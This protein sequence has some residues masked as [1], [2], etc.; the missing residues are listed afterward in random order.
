MNL[1]VGSELLVEDKGTVAYVNLKDKVGNHTVS[2]TERCLFRI[3]TEA[4]FDAYS[5]SHHSLRAFDD[6][7]IPWD[8]NKT[9]NSKGNMLLSQQYKAKNASKD[10]NRTR[11]RV[12]T[13]VLDKLRY[14]CDKNTVLPTMT[15]YKKW[16]EETIKNS[17][18]ANHYRFSEYNTWISD[19]DL[20][21]PFQVKNMTYLSYELGPATLLDKAIKELFPE[22]AKVP[23]QPRSSRQAQTDCLNQCL[24]HKEEENHLGMKTER[25]YSDEDNSGFMVER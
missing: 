9:R 24:N 3:L 1:K 13:G 7:V 2:R 10:M 23:I 17:H 6:E 22:L 11:E 4:E 19:I 21:T 5:V 25:R 20:T 12:F 14:K 16:K 15:A 18:N 8:G